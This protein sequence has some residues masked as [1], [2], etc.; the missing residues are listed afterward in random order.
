M[1]K[2]IE[3][4]EYLNEAEAGQSLTDIKH[5]IYFKAK[6]EYMKTIADLLKKE[7]IKVSKINNSNNI[8]DFSSDSFTCSYSGETFQADMSNRGVSLGLNAQRKDSGWY[9]AVGTKY[10]TKV[11]TFAD[12]IKRGIDGQ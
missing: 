12:A 8:D 4:E 9:R 11:K 6:T 1:K 5:D 7:G 10:Y 3:F 2:I